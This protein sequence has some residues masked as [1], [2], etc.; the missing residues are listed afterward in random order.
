[1]CLVV[2]LIGHPPVYIQ[3]QRDLK[4]YSK[5]AP[6]EWAWEEDEK[7]VGDECLCGIDVQT[8]LTSAGFTVEDSWTED[9]VD[10]T[11]EK[12]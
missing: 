9:G 3:T 6:A 12:E 4:R 2:L 10:L 7:Y 11:A 5:V 8:T 1:M